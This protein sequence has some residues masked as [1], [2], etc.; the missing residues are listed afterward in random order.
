[1]LKRVNVFKY[2]KEN[3]LSVIWKDLSYTNQ[4]PFSRLLKKK[5]YWNL[6]VIKCILFVITTLTFINFADTF[7]VVFLLIVFKI[8][9]KQY[10]FKPSYKCVLIFRARIEFPLQ[11]GRTK[12]EIKVC[13][14]SLLLFEKDNVLKPY[15]E[16]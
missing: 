9:I 15:L 14:N 10:Y 7:S 4:K 13:C 3:S 5:K 16:N 1:M 8:L 6:P 2:F 11:K 12:N